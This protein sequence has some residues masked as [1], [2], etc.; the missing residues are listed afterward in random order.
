MACSGCICGVPV[1]V[2]DSPSPAAP[3]HV[4][5]S[6]IATLFPS[7][8]ILVTGCRLQTTRRPEPLSLRWQARWHLD[9]RLDGSMPGLWAQGSRRWDGE[10][11]N[12]TQ[13]MQAVTGRATTNVTNAGA[14][15]A[16]GPRRPESQSQ[17]EIRR[18]LNGKLIS[19]GHSIL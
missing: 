17:S 11:R 18:T 5:C 8:I 16:E 3:A 6:H 7:T 4:F 12:A 15:S 10:I 1:H 13:L 2:C 14:G 9:G 19:Y